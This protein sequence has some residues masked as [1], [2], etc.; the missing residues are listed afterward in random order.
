MD[1]GEH[2]VFRALSPE[3][4]SDLFKEARTLSF[5][6]GDLIYPP[7][8]DFGR[9]YMLGEGEA[10]VGR[11]SPSGARRMAVAVF[12]A[13]DIF[14]DL[15]FAPG[16]ASNDGETFA[17]SLSDSRAFCLTTSAFARCVC[18]EKE[19]L[20]TLLTYL[21]RRLRKSEAKLGELAFCSVGE[22]L[23]RELVGWG[24]QAGSERRGGLVLDKPV[25]HEQLA[26]MVGASRETVTD[27]LRDLAKQGLVTTSGKRLVVSESLLQ[28]DD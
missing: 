22:R 4:R 9:V 7:G 1:I 5:H 24:K 11:Y 28:A 8:G 6:K 13:G 23:V 18:E 14:G 27:A 19:A 20:V 17:E 12:R 16:L 2:P 21:V 10:L 26:A 3:R 25:T 15:S